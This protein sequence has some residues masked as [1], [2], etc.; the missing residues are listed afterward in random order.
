MAVVAVAPAKQRGLVRRRIEPVVEAA[1]DSVGVGIPRHPRRNQ[2]AG[3]AHAIVVA[4]LVRGDAGDWVRQTPSIGSLT[5]LHLGDKRIDDLAHVGPLAPTQRVGPRRQAYG[6]SEEPGKID[7]PETFDL[8][9]NR[10]TFHSARQNNGSGRQGQRVLT[11]CSSKDL[12]HVII[13]PTASAA[14]HGPRCLSRDAAS[15]GQR[16]TIQPGE[17]L[18]ETLVTDA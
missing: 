9:Q 14:F 12:E 2:A 11:G 3:Q 13:V 1:Q 4:P 15:A 16:E 5:V 18:A 8:F 6:L 10:S 17:V 7:K